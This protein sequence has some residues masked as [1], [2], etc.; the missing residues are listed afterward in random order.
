MKNI[1][2]KLKHYYFKSPVQSLDTFLYP[3]LAVPDPSAIPTV[4]IP[5]ATGYVF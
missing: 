4:A 5:T 2:P 1:F 3:E